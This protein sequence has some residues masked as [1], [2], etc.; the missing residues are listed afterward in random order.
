MRLWKTLISCVAMAVVSSAADALDQ[1]IPCVQ[2]CPDSHVPY[3]GTMPDVDSYAQLV[4]TNNFASNTTYF[5]AHV[6]DENVWLYFVLNNASAS[7]SYYQTV[8][9]DSAPPVIDTLSDQGYLNLSRVWNRT[10]YLPSTDNNGSRLYAV[11][12]KDCP[13]SAPDGSATIVTGCTNIPDSLA[14]QLYEWNFYTGNENNDLSF[15]D[16]F[17]FPCRLTIKNGSKVKYQAGFASK[18]SDFS[19]P[20]TADNI[21]TALTT[22]QV[23]TFTP[24]AWIGEYPKPT[25]P[26]IVGPAYCSKSWPSG[27]AEDYFTACQS[28]AKYSLPRVPVKT[29]ISAIDGKNPIRV[30]G[31]SK[32]SMPEP[33]ALNVF[34]DYTSYLQFLS[35]LPENVDGFYI[36]FGGNNGFSFRLQVVS[37]LE[38]GTTSTTYGLRLFNFVLDRN[39]IPCISRASGMTLNQPQVDNNHYNPAP[40]FLFPGA[41]GIDPW[42]PVYGNETGTP[43]VAAQPQSS[44]PT[45]RGYIQLNSTSPCTQLN[46]PNGCNNYWNGVAY[47]GELVIPA[48]GTLVSGGL[49]SGDSIGYWTSALIATGALSF[50][51]TETTS[52]GTQPSFAVNSSG[53]KPGPV[54]LKPGVVGNDA[55]NTQGTSGPNGQMYGITAYVSSVDNC[56]SEGGAYQQILASMIGRTAT[57][58]QFGMLYSGWNNQEFQDSSGCTFANG[59]SRINNGDPVQITYG[60]SYLTKLLSTAEPDPS[61]PGTDGGCPRVSGTACVPQAPCPI[62][63]AY[64]SRPGSNNSPY[65]FNDNQGDA[66]AVGLGKFGLRGLVPGTG[67]YAAYPYLTTY[68]D[69]FSAPGFNP[70]P[71]VASGASIEW[72]LGVPTVNACVLSTDLDGDG[73]VSGQDLGMLLAAWGNQNDPITDLDGDGITAGEDLALLLSCLGS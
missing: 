64:D 18:S 58:L 17:S 46:E 56:N 16:Q 44:D 68:G 31:P 38:C 19:V 1:D 23:P 65:W 37:N 73:V 43:L 39:T 34:Q 6:P 32:A 22:G 36:D 60:F 62:V 11:I 27:L 8:C 55:Y 12:S 50:N 13:T 52:S 54:Y 7:P 40:G 53:T 71:A 26:Y 72:E 29:N 57:V 14:Y 59:N 66:F 67:V 35:Q 69:S 42:P 20:S 63:Y 25:P 49:L 51:V 15:V 24:P 47:A 9:E 10:L 48:D 61:S 45:G 3:A 30:I 5:G 2:G 4:I 21:L 33:N 28:A 70:D 41:R